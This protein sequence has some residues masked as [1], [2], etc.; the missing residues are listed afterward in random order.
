M[1]S[2]DTPR[3][4]SLQEKLSLLCAQL[5][6]VEEGTDSEYLSRIQELKRQRDHRLFVAETF[7]D[8]ELAM[9]RDEFAHEKESAMLQYEAKKTELKECLLHDLQDKKRAYDNYRNTV[10][11]GTSVDSI[12]SKTMVTRKLRRRQHCDPTPSSEK[13]RKAATLSSLVYVLDDS[14]VEDDV[15]IICK[16]R[17]PVSVKKNPPPVPVG[18]GESGV[19]YEARIEE[20]R[21]CY[22]SKWFHKGQHVFVVSKEH[23]Q[24]SGIVTSISQSEIWV[25]RLPDNSKLRIYLTQLTRGK[26]VLKRRSA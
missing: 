24:E 15:K 25:K 11:L 14:E 2:V 7:R 1:E 12:E 19:I 17:V 20:G 5:R 9:A 10:E 4:G 8:Y 23:G 26:Y 21:L 3:N 6:A 22:E 18:G 13:R 16:G